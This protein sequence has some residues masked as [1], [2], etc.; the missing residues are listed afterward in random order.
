MTALLSRSIFKDYDISERTENAIEKAAELVAD[1]IVATTL[2]Q[3][4]CR[5]VISGG[6]TIQQTLASLSRLPVPWR[7]VAVYM[8]DEC[9]VAPYDNLRNDKMIQIALITPAGIPAEQ[10]FNIHTEI[11]GALATL[12]YRKALAN[13]SHFDIA[14]L[15]VGPDGHIGSLFPDHPS[16]ASTELV[17][18]IS[19]SPKPP[20]DRV[21]VGIGMLQRSTHR[22]VVVVGDEKSGLIAQLNDGARLPVTLFDPTN[23]FLDTSAVSKVL[24]HELT[25]EKGIFN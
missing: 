9:C 6:Q 4:N 21:S 18:S 3:E 24:K 20:S 2:I 25:L 11:G 15:G 1:L 17:L 22:I 14:L 5:I 16:I 23:W 12:E 10:F 19:D 8:A 7:H 13:I